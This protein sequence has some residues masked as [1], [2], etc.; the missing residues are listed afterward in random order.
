MLYHCSVVGY[1]SF[2]VLQSLLRG[3]ERTENWLFYLSANIAV[4]ALII[5]VLSLS[6]FA[7]F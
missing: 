5:V 6:N 3:R 7:N 4:V 2:L 1:Y